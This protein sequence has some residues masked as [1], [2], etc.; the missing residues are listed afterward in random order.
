MPHE[1]FGLAAVAVRVRP[2]ERPVWVDARGDQRS[3]RR[4]RRTAAD[5]R[6]PLD[7][8]LAVLLEWQLVLAVD[9]VDP[10]LLRALVTAEPVRLAPTA[11]LRAWDRQLA[12]RGLPAGGDELPEVC[13]PAR[14]VM[15][16]GHPVRIGSFVELESASEALAADRAAARRGLTLE[17]WAL[18]GA[19]RAGIGAG[20]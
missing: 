6:V 2:G 18:R 8:L 5:A 19:L 15:A 1:G 7:A 3:H 4:W 11:E 9:G 17:S 10:G 16:L 14:I 12:G 20:G 13:L